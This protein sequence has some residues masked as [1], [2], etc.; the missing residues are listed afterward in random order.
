LHVLVYSKSA[1]HELPF[2]LTRFEMSFQKSYLDRNGIDLGNMNNQ[3]LRYHILYVPNKK[4]QQEIREHY[5]T[6]EILRKSDVKSLNI[7]RYRLYIDIF[8]VSLFIS[9]LLKVHDTMLEYYLDN[10]NSI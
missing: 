8:P 1:K 4:K 3:L 9:T 7:E 5:D 2:E 6:K 10:L